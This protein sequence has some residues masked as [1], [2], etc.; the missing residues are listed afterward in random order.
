MDFLRLMSARISSGR[1]SD[2]MYVAK[3]SMSVAWRRS[4][5]EADALRKS[6]WEDRG[7]TSL[8][9]WGFLTDSALQTRKSLNRSAVTGG[10]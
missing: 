4:R 10:Q 1:G 5:A 9:G 3:V 6:M 8:H 7:I 2:D